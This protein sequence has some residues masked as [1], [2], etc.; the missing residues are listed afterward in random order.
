MSQSELDSFLS[1]LDNLSVFQNI[2][3]LII[4]KPYRY[5]TKENEILKEMI[6]RYTRAYD[7]PIVYDVA[8]GH[9]AP[10]ITVPLGTMVTLDSATD[11]FSIDELG[12]M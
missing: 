4:G 2:S 1:D 9:T 5:S 11:T 7:Y 10:I 8:I 3:G 6:E 12:V